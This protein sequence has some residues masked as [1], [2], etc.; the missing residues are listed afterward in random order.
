MSKSSLSDTKRTKEPF[1]PSLDAPVALTPDQ[2]EK[3]VGGLAAQGGLS[4]LVVRGGTMGII[5]WPP[6][7]IPDYFAL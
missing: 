4:S 5:Q 7:K 1:D 6:Y 2:I 3:V